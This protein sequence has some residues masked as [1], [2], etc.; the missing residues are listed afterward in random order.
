MPDTA[1]LQSLTTAID[2]LAPTFTT[3]SDRIWE[4][5]ELK[6]QEVQSS[7]LFIDTMKQNG[8]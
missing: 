7:D 6:F 8:F 2:H 5:A 3:L 1:A 4:F